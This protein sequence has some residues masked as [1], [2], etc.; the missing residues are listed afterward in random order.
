VSVFD[1]AH[2]NAH[3]PGNGVQASIPRP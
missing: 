1:L 2:G 3:F